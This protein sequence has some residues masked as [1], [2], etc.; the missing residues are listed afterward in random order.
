MEGVSRCHVSEEEAGGGTVRVL[1][2]LPHAA[3]ALI[4]LESRRCGD[5]PR[6]GRN[7]AAAI[8]IVLAREVGDGTASVAAKLRAARADGLRAERTGSTERLAG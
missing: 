5:T 6:R 4:R 1:V 8:D 7:E 3:I 2:M